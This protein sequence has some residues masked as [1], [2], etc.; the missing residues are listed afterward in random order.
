MLDQL[1]SWNMESSCN[2]I[3][4]QVNAYAGWSCLLLRQKGDRESSYLVSFGG[5]SRL[6]L[7][8]RQWQV[9]EACLQAQEYVED[10]LPSS[11]GKL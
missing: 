11:L 10:D 3:C 6:K 9:Y 4:G 2:M 5:F 8:W 1:S 7:K